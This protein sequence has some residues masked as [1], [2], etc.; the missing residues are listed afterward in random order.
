MKILVADRI[1]PI[2]VDLF[3]AQAGFEV[4]E[5]YGSSPEQILELAKDV[6]A[7]AVRSDT[8]VTAEV[9]AA[10]PQLKVVGRAGVGVDNIDIEA[11]T[12]NGVIVMNTP[13]GNTIATAELTFT[14]MLAGTRPIVQAC[15]RMREGGWDRKKFGGSEL[16]QKTLGVLGMGRIGAEVAKRAM[17]FQ[18]DVLA[19]DPYLTESRANALGVKMATLDEVIEQADYITV[20]MPLTADTKHMLNA[21]AFGRMKDGVRVFN[22][23]R[24]GI[25]DEAALVDALNSGKVAAAGLDVY[26][27][28][29]PAEDSPLR[30]LQ[31]LVLTPHLGASTAEAQENVGIDVAKQMIEALTGGMVIN[32]LNMPS[33]DPKVLEKLGPYIE[34]GEKLGTFS[35]QLAPE[36]VEKITIRYY[37]K[38]TELDA[39]P[40]TNAIQRGYLREISDNVNNVNAPKKIERLGI[41][42]E[43]VKSSTHADFN[44][45]IEVQVSCKGGKTRTIGGT[46]VGKNQNPRIVTIDGHGVEVNTDATLLVLKNKDVPGIVGFIGVTLGEDEVN[47][48]NMSLSR[49][50]GEGF[51]VSVFELDTAPSEACATKITEHH[52]IEKYRVIKL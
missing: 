21:D 36:G 9:I 5:A 50:K 8:K 32:A 24:G 12:D 33:V 45:L 31:N 34:L 16:N 22:C 23:A 30:G 38:I 19:Y 1:S 43:Q 52:A 20:H 46:L 10:A 6:D 4:I 51:A 26:E 18:M 25:I 17:A 39:L 48:A 47:I 49:D 37:G 44:E 7:I 15:A 35:Q 40:L 11:A 3:K 14:H 2:G 27:D 42:T 41:E 29:P 28:E 13:T